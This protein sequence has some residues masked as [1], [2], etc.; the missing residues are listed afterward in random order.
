[1]KRVNAD[2]LI[3]VESE[4]ACCANARHSSYSWYLSMASVLQIVGADSRTLCLGKQYS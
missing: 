3:G 2:I 1:M 4:L